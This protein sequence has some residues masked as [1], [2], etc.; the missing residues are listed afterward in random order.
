M[1]KIIAGLIALTAAVCSMTACTDNKSENS[2]DDTKKSSVQQTTE[3]TAPDTEYDR[4][5]MGETIGAF[6]DAFNARDY[7][8]T[9]EMQMPD[10][11]MDVMEVV[12]RTEDARGQS[13][14][15]LIKGYQDVLYKDAGDDKVDFGGI[16]KAEAV[17][18]SEMANLSI[19]FDMYEWMVDYV[20]DNGGVE[21][22]DPEKLNESF[23]NIGADDISGSSNITES[24]F[25]TVELRD[26]EKDET[27]EGVFYLLG[28][29]GGWKI[30]AQYIQGFGIRAQE[31][32]M[33]E[34]AENIYK[35]AMVAV[36]EMNEEGALGD[37]SAGL[38][39]SSDETKNISVPEDFDLKRF[40]KKLESYY[41]DAASEERVWFIEIN[42]SGSVFVAVYDTG[43]PSI[44][45][46]YSDMEAYDSQYDGMTYDEMYDKCCLDIGG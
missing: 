1:K 27:Y 18:A 44:V 15:E 41:P 46:H 14:E 11:I 7:K 30:N 26:K 25:V 6:I 21:G 43:K 35:A 20:A 42:D 37:I 31:A 4:T 28:Y 22:V 45:G 5:D 23:N 13:A 39:I 36:V 2:K 8:K 19:Y 38:I 32:V 10:G 17:N 34:E 16:K 24:Y 29:K 3:G 9:F 12:A 40:R 33:D